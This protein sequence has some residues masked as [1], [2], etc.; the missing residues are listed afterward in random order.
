MFCVIQQSTVSDIK[1]HFTQHQPVSSLFRIKKTID[2][3]ILKS[4]DI[5]IM[6]TLL[7]NDCFALPKLFYLSLPLTISFLVRNITVM[8]KTVAK[9]D[10]II[11]PQSI[12]SRPIESIGHCSSKSTSIHSRIKKYVFVTFVTQTFLIQVGREL[13][14]IFQIQKQTTQIKKKF[15]CLFRVFCTHLYHYDQLLRQFGVNNV[16]ISGVQYQ[17]LL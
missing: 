13:W 8:D 7:L 2:V 5:V 15:C 4:I 6:E 11:N 1:K 3:I 16:F 9:K 10:T 14:N 12:K 17:D